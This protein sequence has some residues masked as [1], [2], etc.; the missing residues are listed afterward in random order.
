MS[1]DNIHLPRHWQH[2]LSKASVTY[3]HSVAMKLHPLVNSPLGGRNAGSQAEHE[4]AEMLFQE[5]KAIGLKEVKKEAFPVVKWEFRNASLYAEGQTI[6]PYAYPS[7]GTE[8]EGVTAPLVPVGRGTRQDYE[9]L[10]VTGKIVLIDIDM[11]NDWWIT[12]P[13]LEAAHRGAVA[14]VCSCSGGFSMGDEQALNC[15]DFVGPVTI[16]CVSIS[17][18]DACWLKKRHA[19]GGI[20]ITLQVDNHIDPSGVSY[21]LT[22]VIPGKNRHEQVLVG[23]HYDCHF[24]GFQDNNAA[25]GLTLAIAKGIVD[26]GIVPDRDL[27][28]ILHGAEESGALDTRYDW[29]VGAW[30]QVN[31]VR[32]EWTGKTLAYL[33]FE[34]P[35]CH[36]PNSHYTAAAPEL[37]TMLE[38]FRH[39]LPDELKTFRGDPYETG[40]R[41]FS[42]S[43]DWSYTAAGI[44]GMVNAFL[45]NK[46]GEVNDFFITT[47]HSQFD[48]PDTYDEAMFRHHLQ[49]YGLLALYLTDAPLIM[50]DFSHQAVRLKESLR[51]ETGEW[52]Q[53]EV[54]SIRKAIE[55]ME[56]KSKNLILKLDKI[57]RRLSIHE[58]DTHKERSDCREQCRRINQFLL[59][60]FRRFQDLFLRLDWSDVP[61]FGHEHFQQNILMLEA[62][63]EH[64]KLQ[65]PDKALEFLI[66]IEDEW[67]SAHFSREV[68]THFT[69]QV[70]GEDRQHNQYWGTGRVMG[71][72]DLYRPLVAIQEKIQVLDKGGENVDFNGEMELLLHQRQQQGEALRQCLQREVKGLEA[73]LRQWEEDDLDG[74]VQ[75]LILHLTADEVLI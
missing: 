74:L 48:N 61:I 59:E 23:D 41:Q 7:G 45:T 6:R 29:S 8:P 4:A 50:L 64:L 20:N 62:A 33:N 11:R 67:I 56:R 10:D 18:K 26:A 15:Q 53:G 28:F 39:I 34:L 37:F 13:A 36:F 30:N 2:Y 24:W 55:E 68:V 3:A 46:Q 54:L 49:L 63:L 32:R 19:A 75:E 21:N 43:D 47:Y 22:G 27:V 12:Y 31:R 58:S 25:V 35:A 5:M 69:H 9:G 65:E 72:I 38:S 16:P 14:L 66:Q 73:M 52:F 42:W 57:N 40:Y 70:M 1:R 71:A 51:I 60:W 17:R 44:P